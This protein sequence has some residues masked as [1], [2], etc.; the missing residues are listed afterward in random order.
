ML[1]DGPARRLIHS[2]KYE[3][4]VH[5]GTSLGLL[6]TRHLESFARQTAADL[7]IPVP[8]HLRRLRERG[9]NQA[10]LL[11]EHLARQWQMPLMRNNLRRHRWTDPQISLN[12]AERV[13]NVRG[14]FAVS[15]QAEIRGRRII[16]VD[17][18]YTTGSTVNECARTL[19]GSGAAAVF[20]VTA[21]RAVA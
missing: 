13:S 8:L 11:G 12:A 14:A 18:V 21:V 10:V 9:Y 4:K 16:L 1:F 2:F 7:L 15:R 3:Q 19:H 6:T 17:D 20:V 5:F